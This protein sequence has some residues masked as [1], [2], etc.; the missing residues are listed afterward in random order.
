M[1]ETVESLK[2]RIRST[3]DLQSVVKTMKSLAAVKIR[4][5]ERAVESLEDY[6]RTVLMA[7]RVVLGRDPDLRLRTVRPAVAGRLAGV[8][9]G[10]DQG[11]CGQLND[12]VVQRALGEMGRLGVASADRFIAAV[13]ERAAVAL[14]VEGFP[15]AAVFPVPASVAAISGAVEKLLFQIV[16]WHDTQGVEAVYL[17]HARPSGGAAYRPETLRLLPVDQTWLADLTREPWPTRTLPMFTMDRQALFS[18]LIQQ[19]LFAS[20][21]RAFADSLAS[22]NASRLAAMQGAERNIRDRLGDLTRFY[23]QQRQMSITGEL[24]DIV[25]GFEALAGEE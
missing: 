9:F 4:Q 16:E 1:M 20:L 14:Q 2:K 19:Y 17:F 21:F 6:N 3:E 13:G 22:E 12:Q 23:Y 8:V 11:M 5:F 24:L 10:S 18:E 7:L 25:S 15:P